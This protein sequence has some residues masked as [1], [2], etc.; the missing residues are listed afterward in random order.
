MKKLLLLVPALLLIIG[1]GN[2][3]TPA[4]TNIELEEVT[5]VSEGQTCG[6][7]EKKLCSVGLECIFDFDKPDA[8]GRCT[9]T[10]ADKDIKC[11]R[12]QK[13][14]CAIRG[15]TKNG[16]LN[17]CEAHRHGATILH[18]GFCQKTD[19]AIGKCDAIALGIGNCFKVTRG[20][21]FDGK[22][23]IEKNVGGC[24]AELPFPSLESCQQNCM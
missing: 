7:S 4:D 14:V 20:Y 16:Y 24:D 6:G 1:C 15:R 18:D 11:T 10:I 17:E 9:D 13:P 22:K 19:D 2:Q 3:T 23:C 21:E 12:E 8:R 5:T